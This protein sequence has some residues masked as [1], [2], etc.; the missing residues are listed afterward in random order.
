MI[1]REID[2]ERLFDWLKNSSIEHRT[3]AK[4]FVFKCPRCHRDTVYMYRQSGYFTCQACTDQGKPFRGAP[5]FLFR[6]LVAL[7]LQDLRE[8][9]YDSPDAAIKLEASLIDDQDEEDE[10]GEALP[11]EESWPLHCVELIEKEA[12]PG[13]EYLA[14]RGIPIELAEAYQ[15]RY[16]FKERSIAFPMLVS[17]KLYGWQYRIIGSPSK[18]RPKSKNSDGL[19]RHRFV[20][21]GDLLRGCER[22]IL[23]EGPVD[24]IKAGPGGVC[25][26]G[27]MVSQQQV[28]Q[29]LS[30]GV[31]EV[32]VALDPDAASDVGALISKL[33]GVRVTKVELP[34]RA[35]GEKADLGALSFEEARNS[36]RAAKPWNLGM[37]NVY[38][39]G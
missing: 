33:K 23:C 30:W 9:L 14:S 37:V 24:A 31:K 39:K 32:C 29:V 6:E 15:I 35:D 18:F 17:G 19:P 7:T 20:L 5:E 27:K 38:L 21:F 28:D 16:S 12:A 36:V 22:A 11:L 10:V 8:L 13:V 4:S 1:R 25:T 3:I 2:P 34:S 26:M